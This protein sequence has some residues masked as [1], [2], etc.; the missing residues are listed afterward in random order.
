MITIIKASPQKMHHFVYFLNI[1]FVSRLDQIVRATEEVTDTEQHRKRMV[2]AL[3]D[4]A[5]ILC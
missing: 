5:P 4:Q 1:I 3:L 2:P